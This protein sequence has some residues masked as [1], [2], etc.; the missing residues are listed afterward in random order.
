MSHDPTLVHGLM[1]ARI[2]TSQ[3]TTWIEGGLNES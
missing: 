3:G 2:F 1:F